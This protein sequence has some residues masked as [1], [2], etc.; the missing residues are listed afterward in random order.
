MELGMADGN[1]CWTYFSLCNHS[2]GPMAININ[3]EA[4][5]PDHFIEKFK[6][7]ATKEIDALDYNNSWMRYLNGEAETGVSPYDLEAEFRFKIIGRKTIIFSIELHFYDEVY[8]QLTMPADFERYISE[9]D[10]LLN[11]AVQ[12]RYKMNRR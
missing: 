9:H 10:N 1:E 8:E 6:I 11:A 3:T 5:S 4:D 12:N 2:Y 7:M